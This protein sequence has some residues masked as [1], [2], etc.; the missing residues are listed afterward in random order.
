MIIFAFLI[1][2]FLINQKQKFVFDSLNI[3]IY[4]ISFYLIIVVIYFITIGNTSSNWWN[5]ATRLSFTGADP[6]EFSGIMSALVVFP[7]YLVFYS[8]KKSFLLGFVSFLLAA[9]A[10][11]QTLSTGGILTLLFTFLI[12]LVIF[13]K[14]NF[15]KVSTIVIFTLIFILIIINMGFVDINPLLERFTGQNVE[16][17][18]DLTAKRSDLWLIAL[19][20]ISTKPILGFGGSGSTPLW[21][22]GKYIGSNKVLHNLYLEIL[23][24]YGI[25]G[26]MS[27]LFILFII[28]RDFINLRKYISIIPDFK[29]L[30]LPF[31]SLSA[32]LFAGMGLTWLWREIIWFLIG[33]NFALI[34]FV[35]QKK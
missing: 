25:I 2:Q 1:Y 4:T 28:L 15:K 22:T 24:R 16:N 20:E 8:N 32:L 18:S 9:Y 10:I 13:F 29:L 27:F 33:I 23:L 5:V 14:Y 3:S 34:N 11:L 21:L 6:N 19:K 30:L 7:L 12:F 26:F 17:I 35:L 31:I